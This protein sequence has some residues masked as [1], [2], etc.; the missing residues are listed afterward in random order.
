MSDMC[1]HILAV[2]AWLPDMYMY[3]TLTMHLFVPLENSTERCFLLESNSAK[4]QKGEDE[5]KEFCLFVVKKNTHP[6]SPE[7]GV[8]HPCRQLMKML[9]LARQGLDPLLFHTFP[10]RAALGFSLKLHLVCL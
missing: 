1:F 5:E 9:L 4:L 8:P 2:S 3:F 7:P 6:Q 10:P